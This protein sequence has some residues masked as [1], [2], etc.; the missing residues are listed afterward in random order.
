MVSKKKIMTFISFTVLNSTLLLTGC[1][2]G[3]GNGGGD[4]SDNIGNGNMVNQEQVITDE[5]HVNSGDDAG[6]YVVNVANGQ[7][8]ETGEAAVDKYK[9]KDNEFYMNLQN[10]YN[11]EED[12]ETLGLFERYTSEVQ[13]YRINV[14]A[15]GYEIRFPAKVNEVMDYGVADFNAYI[16][17]S[18]EYGNVPGYDSK[19]FSVVNIPGWFSAFS[20][21]V[22]AKRFAT[23]TLRGTNISPEPTKSWGDIVMHT[24]FIYNDYSNLEENP[25]QTTRFDVA[26]ITET[27]KYEDIVALWGE[28]YE[29]DVTHCN[30]TFDYTWIYKASDSVNRI[31]I[32]VDFNDNGELIKIGLVDKHIYNA[33]DMIGLNY[34]NMSKADMQVAAL[35][36]NPDKAKQLAKDA[37]WLF[38]EEELYAINHPEE[39]QTT[40]P[41]TQTTTETAGV[42]EPAQ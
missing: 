6:Y 31:F 39:T 13:L 2:G 28:P 10:T 19:N 3:G 16:E 33:F 40:V 34:N 9:Y 32:M 24:L 20:E 18:E 36:G 8:T 4:G 27:F 1:G 14:M 29:K 30:E 37:P 25:C 35:H 23:I 41:E 15:N 26:G 11:T 21:G 38:T 42:S 7:V 17:G 5:G 12:A 22:T